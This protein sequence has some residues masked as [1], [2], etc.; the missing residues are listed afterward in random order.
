[1]SSDVR[2]DESVRSPVTEGVSPPVIELP[3][4]GGVHGGERV[5]EEE[6]VSPVVDSSSQV[7]PRL[8]P[9]TESHSPL[10]HQCQVAVQQLS[11]VLQNN[12]HNTLLITGH[13]N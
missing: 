4:D 13:N 9:P 12:T 8:L 6:E 7:H 10:P 11:H 5:V 2:I 3:G 1:M